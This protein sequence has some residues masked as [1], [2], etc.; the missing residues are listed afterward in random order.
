VKT[1][2]LRFA[3]LAA[4][5]GFCFAGP[6]YAASWGKRSGD[7]QN[8]GYAGSDPKL[9]LYNVKHLKVLDERFIATRG[10][11]NA[12]PVVSE[13]G[14]LVVGDWQG[15]VHIVDTTRV[16][17]VHIVEYKTQAGGGGSI[18][19]DALGHLENEFGN[20]VGVQS[21]AT[22]A[23]VT[24]PDPQAPGG[25][26]EERRVYIGVNNR[27]E[28]MH[29][30]N[31]DA[32]AAARDAGL[33]DQPGEPYFCDGPETGGKKPWP[34]PL[35]FHSAN[36]TMNGSPM[37]SPD[38]EIDAD[39]DGVWEEG[40]VRD[41]LYTPST[42]LDCA[43]GRMYAIDAYSGQ[44]YWQFDPVESG[45]S[46]GG[47]IWTT[48][49]MNQARTMVYITTGDCVGQPQAGAK[50][51]SLIAL[52]ARTGKDEWFHQRRLVDTADLD[53][54][55]GPL[56]ADVVQW[57]RECHVVVS[58]DKDGCVYGFNQ[59]VDI[60]EVTPEL[61][62]DPTTAQF[63]F[64]PLR[65]G[66]QRLLYRECFVPG[67]LNGGFNASNPAFDPVSGLAVAQATGYPTGHIGADDSNA[68][69]IDVCTG[70]VA[71]A[72][73]DVKNGRI[74]S[75]VASGML[76]QLGSTQKPAVGDYPYEFVRELQIVAMDSELYASPAVLATVDLTAP[77]GLRAQPTLGGG[78][79][80]IVDGRIYVPTTVGIVV[81]GHEPG[82]LNASPPR[83]SGMNIF[84]G[85]Y[86][87]PVAPGALGGGVQPIDKDNPYPLLLDSTLQR[88]GLYRN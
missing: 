62:E 30:L 20:Y 74:D 19:E 4:M 15:W 84:A 50:A 36:G 48:P 6:V 41:V 76:F 71:W 43:D 37:F 60:P 59:E 56:V 14:L 82:S 61:P 88:Y 69:A 53:I 21:T 75:A 87:Q 18:G 31:L 57:N 11:V 68:F 58:F 13:D 29:C 39:G 49:A 54:G 3:A 44:L 80:A 40:E 64:D 34:M 28:T 46:T 27:N 33:Q 70:R 24:V 47:T 38:Q 1:N 2:A 26:R 55:T 5:A 10:I 9:Q 85:P 67:S 72:S 35:A 63:S 78:G 23:R 7:L 81:I 51:E 12:T 16:P 73:S 83:T 86:T 66:Q 79:P 25:S 65:M 42:G 32:I 17:P 77:D 45:D 22:L 8:T 52:D